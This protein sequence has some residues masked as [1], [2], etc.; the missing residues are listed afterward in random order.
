ML[1]PLGHPRLWLCP[2]GAGAA[3]AEALREA[4]DASGQPHPGTRRSGS[5]WCVNTVC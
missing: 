4:E 5:P 2:E 1:I 3:P